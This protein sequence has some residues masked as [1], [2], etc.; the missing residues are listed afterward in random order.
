MPDSELVSNLRVTETPS[1]I[2]Q[3]KPHSANSD[4]RAQRAL[5]LPEF[6][7]AF[8]IYKNVMCEAWPTRRAELDAYQRDII[9][10]ATRYGGTLIYEYHKIFAQKSAA[11]LQ[12]SNIKIDWSKRDKKFV[13][14]Y[15][16]GI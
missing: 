7:A 13:L 5:T 16:F 10:M 14:K 8:D 12:K 9:D 4:S 15:F 1:G 6:L 3:L 2:Y 11:D